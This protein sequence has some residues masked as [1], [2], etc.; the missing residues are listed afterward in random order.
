[1]QHGRSIPAPSEPADSPPL[2][3]RRPAGPRIT[4]ALHLVGLGASAPP[5]DVGWPR[6][7][8]VAA[9]QQASAARND[10]RRTVQKLGHDVKLS[11][12]YEGRVGLTTAEMAV[13]LNRKPQTL[14]RWSSY[15]DGPL[16]PKRINGRLIWL[17]EDAERVIDG[18][19]T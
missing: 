18:E 13:L 3:R 14:R 17:I 11:E 9:L 19:K 4:E 5:V 10:K 7:G 12:I 6:H 8:I 1:M 2:A 16:R 15:E